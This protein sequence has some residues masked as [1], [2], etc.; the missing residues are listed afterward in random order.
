MNWWRRIPA[1]YKYLAFRALALIV[2]VAFPAAAAIQR[3]GAVKKI[4]AKTVV[5]EDGC[6]IGVGAIIALGIAAVVFYNQIIAGL[7]KYMGMPLVLVP[8]LAWAVLWGLEKAQAW[9]PGLKVVAF[10][11]AVGGLCGWGITA[12][13]CLLTGISIPLKE[14]K[15][16]N[17]RVHKSDTDE[18]EEQAA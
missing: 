8:A 12:L 17:G 16:R 10:W 11:W 18:C 13:G 7:K 15:I 14:V 9:I 4:E 3:F 2:A 5:I 6:V 1:I